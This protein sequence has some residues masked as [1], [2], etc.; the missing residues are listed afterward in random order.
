[1]CK[2]HL[3]KFHILWSLNKLATSFY[4]SNW[5]WYSIHHKSIENTLNDENISPKLGRRQKS[6]YYYLYSCALVHWF[7]WVTGISLFFNWNGVD[8]GLS[9]WLSGKESA[10]N[11]GDAGSVPESGRSPREGNGNTPLYSCLG[12]SIDRRAWWAAVFGL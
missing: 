12:N 1:M 11:T 8:L 2:R 6:P 3:T 9:W 5:I 4:K 7:I 10:C